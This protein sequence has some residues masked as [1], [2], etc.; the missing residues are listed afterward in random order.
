MRERKEDL[1]EE[2][3]ERKRTGKR[4]EQRN[5]GVGM[6]KEGRK[7]VGEKTRK[8]EADRRKRGKCGRI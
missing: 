8:E 7:H 4:E 1:Y 5:G 3:R 2:G 6:W